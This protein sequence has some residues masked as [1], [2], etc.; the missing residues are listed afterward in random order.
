MGIGIE[1]IQMTHHVEGTITGI[2]GNHIRVA[3]DSGSNGCATAAISVVDIVKVTKLFRS[4]TEITDK[5]LK[6]G[7]RVVVEA[8]MRGDILEA[9]EIRVDDL[10]PAGPKS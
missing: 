10:V 2:D 7:D 6:R 8:T 4:G 5:D 1:P 3:E 9:S